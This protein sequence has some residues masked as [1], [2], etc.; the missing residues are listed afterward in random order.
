ML[1]YGAQTHI[2][3]NERAAHVQYN[4]IHNGLGW[5]SVCVGCTRTRAHTRSNRKVHFCL[6]SFWCACRLCALFFSD[7]FFHFFHNLKLLLLDCCLRCCAIEITRETK[8]SAK[9]NS[10]CG[11][12]M[13]AWWLQWCKCVTHTQYSTHTHSHVHNISGLRRKFT[14]K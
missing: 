11:L 3:R 12:W 1:V 13:I 7:R 10:A 9:S 6:V 5:Y 8:H 4:G 2:N 14:R